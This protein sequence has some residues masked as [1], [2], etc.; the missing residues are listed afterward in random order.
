MLSEKQRIEKAENQI[1]ELLEAKEEIERKL[2]IKKQVEE[3]VARYLKIQNKGFLRF[4]LDVFRLLVI[5][6]IILAGGNKALDVPWI[7]AFTK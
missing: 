4:A 1:K 6:S 3:E 7:T 2:R 5:L